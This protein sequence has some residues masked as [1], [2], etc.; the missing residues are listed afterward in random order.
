MTVITNPAIVPIICCVPKPGSFPMPMTSARNETAK[1]PIPMIITKQ[2]DSIDQTSV[3][4]HRRRATERRLVSTSN[5]LWKDM[6]LPCCP[7]T[8]D[9]EINSARARNT[10]NNMQTLGTLTSSLAKF[11][12]NAVNVGISRDV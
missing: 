11:H 10:P 8:L 2:R 7:E 3:R 6:P 12:R 4:G 9:S 1:I 5:A